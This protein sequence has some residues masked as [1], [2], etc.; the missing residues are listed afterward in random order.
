M[1]EQIKPIVLGQL[2]VAHAHVFK[3]LTPRIGHI[4][5]DGQTLLEEK[6]RA[7]SRARHLAPEREISRQSKRHKQL[8]ESPSCDHDPLAEESEKQVSA[9]VDGNK[10]K[11]EPLKQMAAHDGV[12]NQ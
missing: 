3:G 7:E 11:I 2:R 5:P 4:N 1:R 10:H 12:P 6:E 9:F 8:K